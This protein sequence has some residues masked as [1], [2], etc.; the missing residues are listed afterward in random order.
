MPRGRRCSIGCES[1]PDEPIFA[2]CPICGETTRRYRGLKPLSNAEAQSVLL[3]AEFE[4]Y[5]ARYCA[6]RGQP[7]EGPLPELAIP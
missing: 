1:W 4:T 2:K 5:Y 7:A 3:N 6:K